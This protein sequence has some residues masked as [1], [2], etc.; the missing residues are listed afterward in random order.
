MEKRSIKKLI[1]LLASTIAM[2]V[3]TTSSSMCWS[4]IFAEPKMPKSLYKMD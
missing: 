4:H 1:A 3:A 2:L